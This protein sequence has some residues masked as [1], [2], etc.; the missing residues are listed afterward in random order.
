MAGFT[1]IDPND[2]SAFQNHWTKIRSDKSNTIK[3]IIHDEDKVAGYVLSYLDEE[4]GNHPEV[5]YW[6]GKEYW[7]RGIATKALSEFL[8]Q[9]NTC[10]PIY[11][12][13]AKDNIGSFRVL[14]KCNFK[15]I[16]E[17]KGFANARNK[18]TEEYIL[19]LE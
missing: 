2:R 12:R 7:G 17:G 14:G 6:I 10:R 9:S 18:E 3:T 1:P 4:L 11:A 8:A 16:G 5:A 15:I 19:K 13:V